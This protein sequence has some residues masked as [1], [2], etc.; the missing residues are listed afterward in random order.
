M[1]DIMD[2]TMEPEDLEEE[3]E[4]VFGELLPSFQWSSKL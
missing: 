4:D 1:A 3:Q 2:S